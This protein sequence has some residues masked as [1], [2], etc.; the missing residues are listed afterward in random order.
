L[1]NFSNTVFRPK[2]AAGTPPPRAQ[3]AHRPDNWEQG[4]HLEA[5]ANLAHELRSPV[6]VLLGYLDVLRE[7]LGE[8][9]SS[10]HKHIF[11]RMNANA[12]DLAQTVE[13]CHGLFGR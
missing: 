12:H 1:P 11:K 9:L 4:V 5:L 8:T 3:R 7:E 2:A 10:R 13:K 6:H